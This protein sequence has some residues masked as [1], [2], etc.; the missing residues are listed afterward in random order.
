[1]FSVEMPVDVIDRALFLWKMG[2]KWSYLGRAGADRVGFN[3]RL[4]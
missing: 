4:D 2:R 1:M 3:E